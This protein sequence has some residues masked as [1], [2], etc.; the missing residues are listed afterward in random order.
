MDAGNAGLPNK[1]GTLPNKRIYRL[2]S[3]EPRTSKKRI[4][5]LNKIIKRKTEMS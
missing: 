3:T 2:R 5:I 1:N 4:I